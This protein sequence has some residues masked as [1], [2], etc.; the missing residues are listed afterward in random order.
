MCAKIEKSGVGANCSQDEPG[1]LGIG[2]TENYAFDLPSV[3]GRSGQVMVFD[4][5]KI[6]K[7]TVDAYAE[8]SGLAGPHRYGN[9]RALV[10]VQINEGLSAQDG[11]TVKSIVD[12]L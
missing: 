12:G 3:P 1:G 5:P 9:E 8:M 4:D 11:K 2:A 6:Y 10:F 7:K